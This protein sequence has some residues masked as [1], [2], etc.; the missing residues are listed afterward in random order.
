MFFD[1]VMQQL[2]TDAFVPLRNSSP[3]GGDNVFKHDLILAW[4]HELNLGKLQTVA[5]PINFIQR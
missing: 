2:Y 3:F 5:Q 4:F 1:S